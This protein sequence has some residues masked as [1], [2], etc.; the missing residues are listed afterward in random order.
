M[1][2]I[3]IGF[4]LI[5]FAVSLKAQ[6]K[7]EAYI[8]KKGDVIDVIVMEHPEFSL[9]NIRVLPDGFIQ[10][11]ALGSIKAAGLTSKQLMDT[12]SVVLTKY[13]VNP[14]V[15]VFVRQLFE[16]SINVFGYVNNPGQYQ[17][18]DTVKVMDAIGM[19]GGFENLKRVKYIYIF[20]KDLTIEKI[21]VKK[22]YKRKRKVEDLPLVKAGDTIY[23][24]EPFK[25]NWSVLSFFASMLA[26]TAAILNVFL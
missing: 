10:Y 21:N 2:R 23:I 6:I 11:P 1:K 24:K 12:L 5:L 25:M 8:I 9:G 18:Y 7:S 13:V 16:Q 14:I 26:A 15:T 3:W 20:H 4:F 22:I 17:I 19:A